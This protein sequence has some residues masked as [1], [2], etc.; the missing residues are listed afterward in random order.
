M[1]RRREDGD[2]LRVEYPSGAIQ[3]ADTDCCTTAVLW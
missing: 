2:E 1:L 3:I